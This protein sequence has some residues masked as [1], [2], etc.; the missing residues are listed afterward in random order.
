MV[1]LLAPQNYYL[2]GGGRHA[3][4]THR[5]VFNVLHFVVY[6]GMNFSHNLPTVYQFV[7]KKTLLSGEHVPKT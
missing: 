2:G 6:T 7:L 5:T 4:F 3:S 1:T